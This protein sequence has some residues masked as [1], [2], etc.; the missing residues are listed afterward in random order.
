MATI[1]ITESKHYDLIGRVT[2]LEKPNAG[3]AGMRHSVASSPFPIL[4]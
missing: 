1:E 4:A 3:A 2:K